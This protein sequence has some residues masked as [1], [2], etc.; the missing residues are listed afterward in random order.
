[1]KSSQPIGI[2]DSGI[3]GL[4]VANAIKEALP[5]ENL[6]Y[7]GDIAHLPYGDKSADS[8]RYYCIKIS[9]FLLE[10]QCKKIVIACNSAASAAYKVLL[11]FFKNEDLF[12]SVV[13]PMVNCL[14]DKNYSKIGVIATKATVNSKAY[15]EKINYLYPS[16]EVQQ[17][18]TPLLVPMIEEGF[19]TD[20]ISDQIIEKYLSNENLKNIDAL[21]LAC[22]HYPL[23][24]NNIN[25]FYKG[26]VDV[27]D[28]AIP[29][30]LEVK[31]LLK[32]E[33]LLN[34]EGNPSYRFFVSDY[35]QSFE[36]TTKLFY[37]EN[38]LLEEVSIW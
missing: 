26:K 3:G 8:I 30:A 12:I 22:T 25:Q 35:T 36:E 9:Q 27:V 14:K 37:D 38:I 2:F 33:N 28:S 31:E 24:K 29:V 13:D 16:I 6:V 7:F 34:T 32:K 11:D 4:T 10:H 19:H 21:L 17:L 20:K 23:I 18:A 5:N 1:M 15:Q